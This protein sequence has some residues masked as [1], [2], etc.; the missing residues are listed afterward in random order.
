MNDVGASLASSPH[1]K[2]PSRVG[3]HVSNRWVD[4]FHIDFAEFELLGRAEVARWWLARNNPGRS[5]EWVEA[6]LKPEAQYMR[7]ER[8]RPVGRFPI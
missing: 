5:A 4:E 2:G 8:A 7:P 3:I 1:H 6:R